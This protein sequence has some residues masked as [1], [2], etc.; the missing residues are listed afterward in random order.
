M[1]NDNLQDLKTGQLV[2]ATPLETAGRFDHRCA[3][4]LDHHPSCTAAHA[5]RLRLC[6]APGAGENAL[7]APQA[8]LLSS[9]A[10]GIFGNSLDWSRIGLG[11]IIGVCVIILDEVLRRTKGWSLPPL[12]VGMGIYLPIA[13]TLIIPIGAF[14]GLFYDKWAARQANPEASKRMGILLATGAIVG[15]SLFGVF[16]AAIVGGSGKD[17]P[18]ALFDFGAATQWIGL[19]VFAIMVTVLYKWLR[20]KST[21]AA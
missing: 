3:V 5:E 15:E 8:A 6:G 9:V 18:L 4:R 21:E 1:S 11:A 12:S 10:N 2:S 17:E 7:A 13:L 16:N 20:T 19:V 14:I